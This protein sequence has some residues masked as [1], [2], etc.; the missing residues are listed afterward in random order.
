M[1]KVTVLF[2]L[3]LSVSAVAQAKVQVTSTQLAPH[4]YMIKGAGGNIAAVVGP[5]G[6]LVVDSQYE[7]MAP[8][9]KAELESKQAS[10]QIKT[11][12]NTHFHG[13]H[14]NGNAALAS[15]AQIIAH[16]NVL[17]RLKA[18]SKF[19]VAGLPTET[20]VGEKALSLNN[21][22]LDLV[23]MPVS[24]TDGDLVVWFKEANVLHMGDLFFADRFPFID[25]NSG[26]DVA[27]YINNV[28]T[29][30]GQIDDKTRL[31]PGH[32]DLMDK[33]GLQRFLSMMEQ[34]LAEVNAMKAEGKTED[35]IVAQGL[36]AQW[37]S[38]SWNFIT[39][40]RWIRTLFKA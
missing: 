18:D 11:L 14:V 20:F 21:V 30:L 19:P 36:S 26:G 10:V 6:A 1:K 37:K 13:D 38:W 35:Q 27:G 39:E 25:L 24:H 15:G 23:T 29:L 16:T 9:I 33:A 40:E 22:K 7:H 31:I 34:T 12:I 17:T 28:K 5:E 3:L 8:Q 2:A 32:G 4:L